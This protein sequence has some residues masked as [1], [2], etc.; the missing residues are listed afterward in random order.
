MKES[1]KDFAGQMPY[2][3]QHQWCQCTIIV[4]VT[5]MKIT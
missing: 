3:S 5:A 2:Q 1:I 4:T